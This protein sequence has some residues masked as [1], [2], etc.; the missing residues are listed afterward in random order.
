MDPTLIFGLISL[1]LN[2]ALQL[3]NVQGVTKVDYSKLATSLE[4]A[5]APLIAMIPAWLK[6]GPTAPAVSTDILAA[7][8]TAIGVLNTLKA[9]PGL[10]TAMV[11]QIEE[12]IA[13]AQDGTSAYLK[14]SQGFDPT[15]FQPVNPMPAAPAIAAV[16]VMPSHTA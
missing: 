5:F 10:S 13:G 4:S 12:Y 3:L 11:S 15:Q 14:A 8:G 6:G 2:T 1:G 9:T 7:Y 16:P